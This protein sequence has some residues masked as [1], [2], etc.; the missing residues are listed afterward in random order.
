M[1]LR[2]RNGCPTSRWE[3]FGSPLGAALCGWT[4]IEFI[5]YLVEEAGADT[6]ILSS[7]LYLSSIIQKEYALPKAR[8]LVE[9][10]YVQASVLA[11]L[12]LNVKPKCS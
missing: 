2:P 8:Y 12:G 3:L 10:G 9:G 1:R 7:S 6:S 11:D 4:G 5:K